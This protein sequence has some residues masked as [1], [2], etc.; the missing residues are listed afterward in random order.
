M[1]P[2]TI[3]RASETNG[4]FPGEIVR[5]E[6]PG[7][8]IAE[9]PRPPGST[10]VGYRHEKLEGLAE[11]RAEYLTDADPDEVRAFYRRT[12]ARGGW[13]VADLGFSPEEWYFFVVKDER[14]ATV[15]IQAL[16]QPVVVEVELTGPDPAPRADEDERGDGYGDDRSPGGSKR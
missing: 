15:E 13:V 2:S 14:E 8:D 3:L 5:E 4:Q 10:R 7:R 6:V 16:R 9:L 11:T 1:A 12:F